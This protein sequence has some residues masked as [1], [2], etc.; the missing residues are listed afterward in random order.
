M[1]KRFLI[2]WLAKL[3][4]AVFETLCFYEQPEPKNHKLPTGLVSFEYAE[5]GM[6]R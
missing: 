4:T 5:L 1:R 2:E 3:N 6:D